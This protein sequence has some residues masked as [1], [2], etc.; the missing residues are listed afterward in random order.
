M[1]GTAHEL[2]WV[3]DYLSIELAD[4]TV[5][6]LFRPQEE[7]FPSGLASKVARAAVKAG[8]KADLAPFD[9]PM[10]ELGERPAL[11]WLYDYQR[12]AVEAV[13][14]PNA[15]AGRGI[16]WVPPAGGKGE[17]AVA[18]GIACL[19]YAFR[20][21]GYTLFLVHRANLVKDVA[22]RWEQRT[23]LHAGRVYSKVWDVETGHRFVAATFSALHAG[24]R[25]GDL[26][27]EDLVDRARAL[28]VDECHVAPASTHKNVIAKVDKAVIRIGLSG[29]PLD[30]GDRRSAWAIGMLG[31]IAYRIRPELLIER[32]A[33]AA[34]RATFVRYSH[35]GFPA[36]LPWPV[37]YEQ[38][39][40]KSK[41]RN[42]LIKRIV[43]VAQKPTLVFVVRDEHG[44]LLLDALAADGCRAAR[45]YGDTPVAE[46]EALAEELR[47]GRLD[48]IVCSVVW[49][50][51]VDIRNL[52]SV[53]IAGAGRSVI[54]SVQRSGRGARVTDSK[55]NYELWD[56]KDEAPRFYR[57]DKDRWR[58]NGAYMLTLWSAERER[59]YRREAHEIR[60]LKESELEHG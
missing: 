42:D 23:G 37:R 30:R 25:R 49:Q 11:A 55:S 10:P 19:E 32:Q 5:E 58:R 18:L 57:D 15:A 12:V 9:P 21:R 44:G 22:D 8:F 34:R 40:V 7:D 14:D 28:E 13:L 20:E 41:R 51:G 2:E 29:T 17:I 26:R 38:C 47:A 33:I 31:P 4:G 35:G 48:A 39:V 27:A 52:A 45:V 3:K 6:T 50:E 53:V 46:R 56:V 1:I 24:F 36:E 54:A 16:I 60:Y 59:A 43:R